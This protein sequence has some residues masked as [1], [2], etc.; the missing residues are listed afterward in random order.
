MLRLTLAMLLATFASSLRAQES[1]GPGLAGKIEG[2][3]YISP[4]GQFKPEILA[5]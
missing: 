4:T 3:H 5:D 2:R 1:V